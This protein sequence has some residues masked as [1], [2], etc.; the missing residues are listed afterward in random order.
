MLFKQISGHTDIK[1]RLLRSSL[2]SRVS[3]ALLMHGPE[4][5]GKFA[6]AMAFAQFL[7]CTGEK[8]EDSCGVCP[9]CQ[10]ASKLIHPDI[11]YVFP[12]A[13]SKSVSAD[14]I[15]DKYIK[16]WREYISELPYPSLQG[17]MNF[18][19]IENKQG[20]I[21]K[22]E[23][24]ELMR[25]LSLKAFESEYKVV[26]IW[27]AEKMN[28]TT[29]NKLLKVIEEP[30]DKTVFLLLA[31]RTE[32]ILPTILSRTQLITVPKLT[33]EDL[34]DGL[35]KRYPAQIE[36][37]PEIIPLAEGNYLQAVNL[38]NTNEQ[39]QFYQEQFIT[40]M[41]MCFRYRVNDILSWLP[42]IASIGR[43]R[44]KAFLQYGLHLIRENYLLNQNLE[45]VTRMTPTEKEFSSKFHTFIHAGNIEALFSC[46]SQAIQ[47]I[48][49]NANPRILFLDLSAEVYKALK[50]SAS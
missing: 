48:E 23:A 35:S 1:D 42:T 13:T 10:K 31:E 45:S 17:W 36:K 47:Q 16:E 26:I 39:I 37:L 49:M 28:P 34:M 33:D 38:L 43:E 6:I 41:R 5:N 8:S 40:W 32:K 2:D 25:K 18:L 12:V 29:A 50:I 19:D 30:P 9:S 7:N 44:Q 15:S 14:P 21:F 20:G 22:K 27:L 4:G 24:D 46:L 3:H 11:H